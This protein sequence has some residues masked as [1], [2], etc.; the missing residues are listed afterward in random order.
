MRVTNSMVSNRMLININRNS[1]TVN[2]LYTQI[3][4]GKRIIFPSDNPILASRALK[5]R[6]SASESEKFQSNVD[7]ANSWMNVTQGAFTNVSDVTKRVRE[8]LMSGSNGTLT[9]GDKKHIG[10]EIEL[11]I[12]QLALEFNTSYAGRYVFSG[13]R[14]DEPFV[15]DADNTRTFEIV[16]HLKIED[17]VNIKSFQQGGLNE[18]FSMITK[19]AVV[20]KLPYENA[21]NLEIF[22]TTDPLTPPERVPAAT[23]PVPQVSLY[24]TQGDPTS[25]MNPEAYEPASYPVYIM[26]TGELVLE[27]ASDARNLGIVYQK[28]DF[29]ALE[30]NPIVNFISREIDTTTAPPTPGAFTDMN[31]QDFQYEF[32]IR[33]RFTINSLGKDVYTASMYSDLKQFIQMIKGANLPSTAD[34]EQYYR[35]KGISDNDLSE[36]VERHLAEETQLLSDI[37]QDRFSVMLGRLDTHISNVVTQDTDLATRVNRLELIETRLTD[38]VINYTELLANTEDTNMAE[39]M[40]LLATAE[41]IYEAALKI[42]AN[43]M[44]ISLVNYV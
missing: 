40:M 15:F 31:S 21:T 10:T 43:I 16:Q 42:G 24:M 29:K 36:Y 37:F 4:T 44:Q 19:N 8:L 14:T 20:I 3:S 27:R 26:E 32:G 5:F 35:D 28:T 30:P 13:Y 6:T 12:D 39:A 11:L 23:T 25:G 34:L 18:D 33:N 2:N 38:D 17:T 1:R 41:A 9:W 22:D 7:Q